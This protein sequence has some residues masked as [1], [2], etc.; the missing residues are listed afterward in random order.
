MATPIL[1]GKEKQGLLNLE[2]L[3]LQS[4]HHAMLLLSKKNLI[5]SHNVKATNNSSWGSY[6]IVPTGFPLENFE[7]VIKKL[8]CIGNSR[9]W[10]LSWCWDVSLFEQGKNSGFLSLQFPMRAINVSSIV[11]HISASQETYMEG[12]CMQKSFQ[13]GTTWDWKLDWSKGPWGHYLSSLWQCL[14]TTAL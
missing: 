8:C 2:L 10:R 7:W 9:K 1:Q 13:S 3:H 6:I 5:C 4:S 11:T 14:A 12:F